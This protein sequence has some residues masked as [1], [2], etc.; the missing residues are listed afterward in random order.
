VLPID[1]GPPAG[2]DDG[3]REPLVA[4]AWVEP[5]A[6][7][8]MGV[9][10][11]LASPEASYERRESVELA[12]VAALQLL[13]A[14]QRAVLILREVLGFSAQEVAAAL[15]TTVASV[16][17]ALQRARAT[18]RQRLPERSQQATVRALGD[19]RVRALVGRYMDA[20]ERGDVEAVLALLAEDATWSMP[21][22]PT[23]YRGRAA[24]ARFLRDHALTVRWRHLPAHANGQA[25]VGCY[26]WDPERGAWLASVLDVLT[27]D[28][29]GIAAITA[30]APPEV[31]R[32]LA[33][34][35]PRAVSSRFAAFG[36]PGELP[37][38][39]PER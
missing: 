8:Q 34:L 33:G 5:Y 9:E 16:N 32:G 10:D 6:D 25:A 17:S 23:W 3:M 29:E 39:P 13:P 31:F 12:F 15:G 19:G 4:T 38:S 37:G 24:L 20:M 28:G 18:I 11:G 22:I 36:L 7:G 14:R 1:H 27:L 35:G 21:P 2:P 26:A 30:F